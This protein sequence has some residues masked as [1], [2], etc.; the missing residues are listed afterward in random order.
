MEIH[1][2]VDVDAPFMGGDDLFNQRWVGEGKESD[3]Q[4]PV[5]GADF[6][7]EVVQGV[8]AHSPA[9]SEERKGP[10]VGAPEH[11]GGRLA[12]EGDGKNRAWRY[13]FLYQIHYPVCYHPGLSCSRSG[14]DQNRALGSVHCSL[15]GII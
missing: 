3:A 4:G 6:V 11:L 2:D 14:Y 8:A 5:R 10:R 9:I 1:D 13:A 12:R 7:L 15:L